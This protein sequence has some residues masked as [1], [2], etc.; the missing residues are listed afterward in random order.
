[1][2][3]L[4]LPGEPAVSVGKVVEVGAEADYAAKTRR[5]RVELPNADGW[6]AGIGAY[7]RFTAPEGEW[8]KRIAAP[9]RADAT[10]ATEQTKK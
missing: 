1:M 4:D 2:P 6:P 3:L 10:R 9:K 5:I 8:A 7:V